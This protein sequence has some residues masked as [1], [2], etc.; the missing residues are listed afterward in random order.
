VTKSAVS[1]ASAKRRAGLKTS[2]RTTRTAAAPRRSASFA[3]VFR[4]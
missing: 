2:G 4:V 1:G 3:V